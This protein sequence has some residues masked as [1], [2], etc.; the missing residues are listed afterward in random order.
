MP[1]LKQ[2]RT[3]ILRE[4]FPNVLV[5]IIESYA[6]KPATKWDIK[7]AKKEARAKLLDNDDYVLDIII[8]FHCYDRTG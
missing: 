5:D 6:G 1:T 8:D 7:R 2:K 4:Y 3:K